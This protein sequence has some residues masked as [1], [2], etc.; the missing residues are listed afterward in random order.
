MHI[1]TFMREDGQNR[2]VLLNQDETIVDLPSRFAFSLARK[3]KYSKWT[4]KEYLKVLKLFCKDLPQLCTSSQLSLDSRIA[5]LGTSVVENWILTLQQR[6]LSDKTIRLRDAVL[7]KFMVWL[8]THEAGQI[9]SAL[10]HPYSDGYLKTAKPQNLAPRY[11]TYKEV[12]E[13]IKHG[14]HNE[15]ER[16]LIHFMHDTGVRVSEIPRVYQVDLPDPN[17]YPT[18]TMYFPLFIRGAKGRGGT[19]KERYTI[20]SLPTLERLFRLHNNWKVYRSA[21]HHYPSDKM[22]AF[23]NVLGKPITTGAIQKQMYTA[24]KRLQRSGLLTKN[25]TPHVLRHSMAFSILCSEHGGNYPEKAVVCQ[26][27]LGHNSIRSTE[28]YTAI[29]AAV[30]AH[31]QQVN[32]QHEIQLRYVESQYVYEYS[33]KPQRDHTEYRGHGSSSSHR[34]NR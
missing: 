31:L 19:I 3:A 11:L 29:P 24:T 13:F 26:R 1:H 17:H 22:P 8:T 34:R 6:G 10:D 9:R 21:L 2:C 5:T 28:I 12:A 4:I 27:A 30:I 18:G 15:S 7:K 16:C 20:I 25:V 32:E 14:F 23:L 33:F